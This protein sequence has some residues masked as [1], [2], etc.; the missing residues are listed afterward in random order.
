MFIIIMLLLSNTTKKLKIHQENS[1]YSHLPNRLKIRKNNAREDQSDRD[2]S[3]FSLNSASLRGL[4]L[5]APND[6][7]GSCN[8]YKP[9]SLPE[10][11]LTAALLHIPG[12]RDTQ[13]SIDSAQAAL[14][15]RVESLME[16]A[17]PD[18]DLDSR[19][20]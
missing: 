8:V 14:T 15:N 5:D 1:Y 13:H 6:N 12:N 19:Q 4:A 10:G 16:N 20:R 2:E 3:M 9:V 11:T 7:N 18:D 17:L